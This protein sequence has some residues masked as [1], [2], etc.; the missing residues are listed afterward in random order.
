MATVLD[1]LENARITQDKDGIR[2]ET[3]AIVTGVTGTA[4]QKLINALNDAGMPSYGDAH[5]Q[6]STI[7]LNNISGQAI[8]PETFRMQLSYYDDPNSADGGETSFRVSS[9]TSTEQVERDN[10]GERLKAQFY[11]LRVVGS[12]DDTPTIANGSRLWTAEVDRPRTTM[13]F[14]YVAS[15]YPASLV[16]DFQ[17]A[18]NSIMWNGYA[19]GTVLCSSIDIEEQDDDY[20][21]RLS[22][23]INEAGWEFKGAVK[24]E[25]LILPLVAHPTA[26]D[27]K[28]DLHT[29]IKLFNLYP[30]VDYTSL[31]LDIGTVAASSTGTAVVHPAIDGADIVAGGKTLILT[32]Y[33]DTW[34]AS[35]ATFD[36]QRQNIIDGITSN[37]SETNGWDAE[38]A[39]T[40]IIAVANV[41]RTSDTIVTITFVLD[42]IYDVT[43]RELISTVIPASALTTSA[44][45]LSAKP[46]FSINPE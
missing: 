17:G 14:S 23:S 4:A 27:A 38:I 7:F 8:D 26:P 5:P 22:F 30:V 43:E 41:V 6:D 12:S 19:A 11:G 24:S 32:L 9:S 46:D 15:T 21:V 3:S 31:S 39:L 10:D 29:G 13:S 2:L 44:V 36:A 1:Q 45:T 33:N 16:Q 20:N 35:G 40:R 34:V 37:K 18:V 28:L 42:T 25:N